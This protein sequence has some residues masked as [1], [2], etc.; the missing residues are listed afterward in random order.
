MERQQ[1]RQGERQAFLGREMQRG[2]PVAGMGGG[3]VGVAGEGT[4]GRGRGKYLG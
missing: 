4:W 3:R 2:V 1:A